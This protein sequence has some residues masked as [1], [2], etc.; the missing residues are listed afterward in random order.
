MYWDPNW[1][2][3]NKLESWKV[4]AKGKTVAGSNDYFG[5]LVIFKFYE[6]NSFRFVVIYKSGM[7]FFYHNS[8]TQPIYYMIKDLLALFQR[9]SYNYACAP[10][11]HIPIVI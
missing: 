1:D 2:L 10:K 9:A 11:Q 5:N 4:F 7:A 6:L 3:S 8:L